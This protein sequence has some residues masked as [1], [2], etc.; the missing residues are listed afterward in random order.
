MNLE[1]DQTTRARGPGYRQI[2]GGG[3]RDQPNRNDCEGCNLGVGFAGCHLF[4][5]LLNNVSHNNLDF[6]PVAPSYLIL[7]WRVK[8]QEF[9]A[10]LG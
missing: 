3:K 5:G 10:A 4:W 2:K 1:T 8:A 7:D 6:A 9:G